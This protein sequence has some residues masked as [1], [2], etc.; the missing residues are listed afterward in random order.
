MEAN[1]QKYIERLHQLQDEYWDKQGFSIP[2][3]IYSVK[4]GRKYA[5]IIMTHERGAGQEIVHS[6]VNLENGDILKAASWA[7]P[8]KTA[9]G[10]VLDLDAGGFSV[11]GASYL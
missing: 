11:H 5:K 10:S 8:A 1:I 4:K 6:F 9:R 7:A 2:Q 3:S